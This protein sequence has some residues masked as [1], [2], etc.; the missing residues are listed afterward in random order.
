[1]TLPKGLYRYT[2]Y[3]TTQKI[4]RPNWDDYFMAIVRIVATRSSCD[5]LR[6]GAVL[7]QDKRI[8]ATG[9]NS[10]PPGL[11]ICDDI[12]HL[13][14]DK[15]CVRTLHSEENAIIQCAIKGISST[16]ST[17]YTAYAPC[18]HCAKVLIGAGVKRVVYIKNYRASKS[19]EYLKDAGVQVDTY[20]DN[21]AWN[22]YLSEMFITPAF[23][24]VAA[25]GNVKLT[26][27]ESDP[28]A[29]Q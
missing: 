26:T 29:N 10:A 15:H 18:I 3:M 16:G 24:F 28:Y 11:P 19:P 4:Y 6:T 13:L 21:E 8:I 14:E 1:M 7:V 2:L 20:Q 9:Y 23:E 17:L 12:G 25:E 27:D 5:R 22:K